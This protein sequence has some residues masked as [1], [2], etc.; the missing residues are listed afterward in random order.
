MSSERQGDMTSD[1]TTYP[2]I[3]RVA[4]GAHVEG[5]DAYKA[6]YARSIKDNEAFWGDMAKEMLTFSRPFNKVREGGFVDG[7]IRWFT[8]GKLNVSYNCIDRHVENGKGDQAA[9]IWEA[10]EPGSGKTITYAELLR[11]VCR[12]ANVLKS[13]G[14][15]RG[16]VVTIYMPMIPETAYVMLACARL[17]CPHSVVFAGFSAEALRGR[18]VDCNS[19][20]VCTADPGNE[21]RQDNAPQKNR[22]CCDRWHS[23]VCWRSCPRGALL[24]VQA[25]QRRGAL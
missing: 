2:T 15:Q 3:E 9:I 23:R 16:D 11:N 17:G 4:N 21:G 18:I 8:G 19:K 12:V 10:D 13:Q 7:D 1:V 24:F 22:R 20:W 14:V 6:M 5:M 25:H